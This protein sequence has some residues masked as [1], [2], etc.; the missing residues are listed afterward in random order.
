MTPDPS[1]TLWHWCAAL[2]GVAANA[3]ATLPLMAA[4]A[5]ILGR[6]GHAAFCL[7]GAAA[8]ARLGLALSAAWPALVAG[9]ALVQ[10]SRLP[11]ATLARRLAVFF[12]PAGAGISL[13]VAV[14]C[15]GMACAF[16]GLRACARAAAALPPGT[17]N[18]SA[19]AISVPLAALLAA[20]A[21]ALAA[22][23]LRN[24]PFA[25]LPPGMDAWRAAGTVLKHA[26]RAY[27]AALASGG[28]VGLP[29]A[30]GAARRGSFHGSLTTAEAVGGVRWCAVWAV[31]GCL[32]QLL[33]RWGVALGLLLRGGGPPVPGNPHAV[34][35]QLVPLALLTLACT[36]WA[37]LL[38]R[39][40]PLR[41]LPLAPTGLA[42]LIL[43]VSAPPALALMVR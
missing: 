12:T 26:F 29:L 7:A 18:Y 17:D 5:L 11:D 28:A 23:A 41:M 22:F 19:R 14:W 32:P 42:L 33:E 35:F 16:V 2:L 9:D 4:L 6:R 10:L 27:F 1:L 25:G 36:A 43:A 34:L 31:A 38:G 39:R 3:S 40:E 8:L 21:C 20:A 24:W 13:S 15:A 37:A 30:A